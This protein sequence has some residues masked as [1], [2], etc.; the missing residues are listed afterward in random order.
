MP[1]EFSLRPFMTYTNDSRP[2]Y[3][4]SHLKGI[5]LFASGSQNNTA[6]LWRWGVS[7]PVAS[8]LH[9]DMVYTVGCGS[10]VLATGCK[11]KCIRLFD[12]HTQQ[13]ILEVPIDL[14][15]ISLEWI[16]ESLFAIAANSAEVSIYDATSGQVVRTLKGHRSHL[17]RVAWLNSSCLL[18]SVGFD[19]TAKLWDIAYGGCV[20][21]LEGHSNAVGCVVELPQHN[22][23]ATGAD[24]YEMRLWDL[25]STACLTKMHYHNRYI[26]SMA[27][28]SNADI[29]LAGCYGG[30]LTGVQPC[31]PAQVY[32]EN[33]TDR[34]SG[35]EA[36]E[37]RR[38]VLVCTTSGTITAKQY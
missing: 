35:I 5:D 14:R 30:T 12:Y 6:K 27:Y 29:L 24:D 33:F 38:L 15:C 18:A 34:I 10:S 36:I 25:S 1:K 21:S 11:D 26:D 31:I 13:A 37:D 4:I 23:V 32:A 9:P 17:Y 20:A 8:I 28:L 3:D 2:V 19:T 16:N 7:D 22:I